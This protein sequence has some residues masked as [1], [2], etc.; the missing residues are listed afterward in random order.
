MTRLKVTQFFD[1]GVEKHLQLPTSGMHICTPTKYALKGF[2][3]LLR[4]ELLSHKIRVHLACPGFRE[5]PV[6]DEVAEVES[7]SE[8][9][10]KLCFHNRAFA[11]SPDEVAAGTLD[12]I[13]KGDFLITTN[14]SGFLAGVLARGAIPSGTV[15]RAFAEFIL[16]IPMKIGSFICFVQMRSFVQ[17]QLEKNLEKQKR[18]ERVYNHK[19]A[20]SATDDDD[21]DLY[22]CH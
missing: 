22:L 2:A 4:V 14:F 8:L 19:V 3:E 10:G 7:T 1:D 12:G 20:D 13:K 15:A 16:L 21:A 5:S 11:K 6:L 17:K 9:L 18:L